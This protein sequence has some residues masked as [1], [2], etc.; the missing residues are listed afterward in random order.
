MSFLLLLLLSVA[1]SFAMSMLV[2]MFTKRAITPTSKALPTSSPSQKIW[3]ENSEIDDFE[4]GQMIGAGT[5][6]QVFIARHVKTNIVCAIK[7]MSKAAIMKAKHFAHVKSEKEI[8][9]KLDFPFVVNLLGY[10]QDDKFVYLILEYVGGGDFF[11]HLRKKE[12]LD[13]TAARFYA[14]QVVLCF[15]YLHSLDIIY[16][17]LKPENL[18]LD[19]KGNMKITDFGFAK[20]IDA[21]TFTLCGTPDYLAPEIILAKGHGKAVDWWMLG[22]LIYEMLAGIAPFA[23]DDA[24]ATYQKILD[25]KIAFPR[26]FSRSAKDL[27]R[28]LLTADLTKRAL[29]VTQ[30]ILK[31][32]K[33][34]HQWSIRLCC[35]KKS[36]L[37]LWTCKSFDSSVG[38]LCFTSC[39]KH[40]IVGVCLWVMRLSWM[41]SRV[42]FSSRSYVSLNV[43][44]F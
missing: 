13:E 15:E 27:I 24:S 9:Q 35:P 36:K 6:G 12:K 10:C 2:R 14:A 5:F 30:R 22:V 41:T 31:T 23:D 29:Q 38:G 1:C 28:K 42:F 21:R 19:E 16:R 7:C 32:S 4:L 40:G 20:K 34:Y 17:D 37:S 11:G 18:V 3:F 33:R 39:L 44:I 8:L 25:G 26:H 43:S